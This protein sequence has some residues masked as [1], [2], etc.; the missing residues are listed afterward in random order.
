MR[1]LDKNPETRITLDELF[2]DD[3]LK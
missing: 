1:L 2:K 3:L